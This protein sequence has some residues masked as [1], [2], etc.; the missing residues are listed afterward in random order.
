[1]S[2]MNATARIAHKH[3]CKTYP[4]TGTQTR[5]VQ[6][7]R[8]MCAQTHLRPHLRARALPL[9]A[10][11][12]SLGTFILLLQLTPLS[13]S[14]VA[15]HDRIDCD[16]SLVHTNTSLEEEYM[17][18]GINRDLD[19]IHTGIARGNG[20]RP[21]HRRRPASSPPRAPLLILTLHGTQ[22][23]RPNSNAGIPSTS[24]H[25]WILVET[26]LTKW[27]RSWSV[28]LMEGDTH[29]AEKEHLLVEELS[30][31]NEVTA[32]EVKSVFSTVPRNRTPLTNEGE[33]SK[34]VKRPPL[35]RVSM[36][37]E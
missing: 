14:D 9:L 13:L 23:R 25:T 16:A 33:G 2:I 30:D 31:G 19:G 20:H 11:F 4:V 34:H 1:M 36:D 12:L 27:K 26:F 29:E 3:L 15:W 17:P 28:G 22:T 7:S 5:S 35:L 6:L 18:D 8:A 24:L 37:I 32:E 10:R 21:A